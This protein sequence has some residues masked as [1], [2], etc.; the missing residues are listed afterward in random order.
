VVV[1]IVL[2]M[3]VQ[4]ALMIPAT[5]AQAPWVAFDASFARTERGQR[6][7]V[8][9]FHRGA[10]GSTREESNVDGPARPVVL[11][12]NIA[13]RLQYKLD[14]GQWHSFPIYLSP[15]GWRPEKIDHDPR[16]YRPAPAVEKIEVLRF[17][18]PQGLV[19]FIAPQLDDF[20]LKTE[21][22]DGGREVFSNIVVRDQPAELFEPPPGATVYVHQDGATGAI[23]YPAR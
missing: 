13:K 1:A 4:A 8:G 20:P 7:V 15:N 11:I 9:F 2:G 19:Q 17:V 3:S 22:P 16:K 10:D 18:N 21:R 12:M 23:W 5:Y 6:R 14:A